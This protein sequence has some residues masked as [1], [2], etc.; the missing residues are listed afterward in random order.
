MSP[1]LSNPPDPTSGP[2]LVHRLLLLSYWR[3]RFLDFLP[4]SAAGDRPCDRRS[5]A[6]SCS[7]GRNGVW[8]ESSYALDIRRNARLSRRYSESANGRSKGW[9]LSLH[10][11]SPNEVVFVRNKMYHTRPSRTS[12]GKVAYRLSPKR[13]YS[14]AFCSF[15]AQPSFPDILSRLP[16][17]FPATPPD[18]IPSRQARHL[19]KYIFPRQFGLHSAFTSTQVAGAVRVDDDD[20][21]LEI[22]VRGFRFLCSVLL[23]N[24]SRSWAPSRHRR[25]SRAS[26]SW[27]R[28]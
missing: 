27:P 2:V 11:R 19:L 26:S 18:E 7:R 21:E 16:S 14:L 5:P 15:R 8:M 28:R 12:A 13:A 4:S 25:D 24:E 17:L 6:L 20:R 22:L 10:R 23:T 3:R 1:R 9:K